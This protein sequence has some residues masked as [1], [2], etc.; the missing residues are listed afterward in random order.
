LF[1]SAE[2]NLLEW[3]KERASKGIKLR[4]I[5]DEDARGHGKKREK[6]KHTVVRYLPS[7]MK[8]PALIEIF[9]DYVATIIVM[10]KPIVFLIRSKEVAQSYLHYFNL[11][12]KQARR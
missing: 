2:E 10:P 9:E 4:V 11:V 5:Y 7:E 8:T 6:L 1:G 3:Q 12:W